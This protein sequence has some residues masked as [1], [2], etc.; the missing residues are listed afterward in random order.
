VSLSKG[1]LNFA[2]PKP[3]GGL[4]RLQ[5]E[6]SPF[7]AQLRA[8]E[9]IRD[10]IGNENYFVE[11]IFNSWSVAEKLSSREY[12]LDLKNNDPQKLFD[13]LEIIRRNRSSP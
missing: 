4:D 10:G 1:S 8:L 12:L 6:A 3:A 7:P 11:T 5:V 13:A 2:Y 9:L